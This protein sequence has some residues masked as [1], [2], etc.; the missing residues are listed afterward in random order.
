M[1]LLDQVEAG[2]RAQ[3]LVAGRAWRTGVW[4]GAAAR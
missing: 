2:H 4:R 3:P 1:A